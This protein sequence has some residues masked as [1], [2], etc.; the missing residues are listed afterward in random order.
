M[1]DSVSISALG[2]RWHSAPPFFSAFEGESTDCV[3]EFCGT[4]VPSAYGITY[5][6]ASFS[7][8]LVSGDGG[9]L[10]ANQDWSKITSYSGQAKDPE[11]ALV[12]AAICSRFAAFSALLLHGS[13]VDFEGNGIVFTGPSGIGKS[14]LINLIAGLFI[15]ESGKISISGTDIAQNYPK[16]REQIGFVPQNVF[17]FDGSLK[18][19]IALGIAPENINENRI[20]EVLAL[21]QLP[22]FAGKT[23]MQLNSASGLSG[24]Q[25]QRIGIARALYRNPGVLILDEATSALDNKTETAFL[26]VLETLRGKTTVIII[27]HRKET[28]DICDRIIDLQPQ[29]E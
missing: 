4:S 14:T 8:C 23:D 11:F 19:N 5:P 7:H 10:T 1:S 26:Q 24:G 3:M 27:S 12:L 9:V 16:W 29:G 13:L 22:E 28:L 18:E 17:I 2:I 6:D 20:R 15:P 21:A 25:R